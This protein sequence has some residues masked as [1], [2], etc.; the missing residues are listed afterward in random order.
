MKVEEK[1]FSG[2]LKRTSRMRTSYTSD[3]LLGLLTTLLLAK[4]A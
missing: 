2:Q 3:T 4:P 1:E